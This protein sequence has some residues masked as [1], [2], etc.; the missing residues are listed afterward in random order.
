MGVDRYSVWRRRL[1]PLGLL[2]ALAVLAHNTCSN[3]TA[4]A[5]IL[6][7]D[8]A[9]VAPVESVSAELYQSGQKVP[10]ATFSTRYLGKGD[11]IGRWE[12]PKL[13]SGIYEL[14]VELLR[15]SGVE[16]TQRAVDLREDAEITID[17][18]RR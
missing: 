1:A 8:T 12:L 18:K 17:L 9:R 10:L 2:L 14:R 3:D 7:L 5:T 4:R 6:F 11:E 15:R 16:L 13:P